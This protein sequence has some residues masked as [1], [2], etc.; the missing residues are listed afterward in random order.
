M[1]PL[2]SISPEYFLHESNLEAGRG[3]FAGTPANLR[4]AKT[5]VRQ[6]E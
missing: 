4:S 5:S 1:M 2:K 3:K 6:T